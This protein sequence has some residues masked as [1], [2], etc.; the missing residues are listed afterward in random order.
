MSDKPNLSKTYL[1]PLIAPVI[2]IESKYLS[3]VRNTFLFFDVEEEDKGNFYV[4][5][6]FSF[7][8]PEYTHYEH[9]LT[10]NQYFKK[11]IDFDNKVLYVFEF[12]KE[13]MHEYNCFLRSEYSKFDEDAKEQI[14]HYWTMILGKSTT[15]ANTI[16][17]IKQILYKEKSLKEQ[18]EKELRI[19]LNSD[20]E[21][22]ELVKI[23][24][25]IFKSNEYKNKKT[26]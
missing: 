8:N 10:D 12:P 13:Y 6:D 23:D 22:G 7:R 19:K 14:L 2:G 26:K 17:K 15:G 9:R 1:L 11:L 4:L 5:Q 18:L 21:L 25:E 20:A 3:L 16:F 24:N